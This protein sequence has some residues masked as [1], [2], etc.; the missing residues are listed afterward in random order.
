MKTHEIFMTDD[1][2]LEVAKILAANGYK[3]EAIKLVRHISSLHL[4]KV[5]YA[6][7]LVNSLK[8]SREFVENDFKIPYSPKPGDRFH[9]NNDDYEILSIH[10][11]KVWVYNEDFHYHFTIDYNNV[12]KNGTKV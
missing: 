2:A 4:E 1:V 12:V 5:D 8:S 10:N 11:D 9:Y 3:I 6:N 7:G